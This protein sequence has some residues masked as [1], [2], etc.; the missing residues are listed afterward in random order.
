MPA[1]AAYKSKDRET[2]RWELEG[3]AGS[4]KDICYCEEKYLWGIRHSNRTESWN[5]GR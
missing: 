5:C 2:D 3:N 4:T 1:K